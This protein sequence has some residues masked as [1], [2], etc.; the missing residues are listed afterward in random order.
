MVS[1]RKGRSVKIKI[2]AV[3][4]TAGLLVASCGDA[5]NRIARK[6]LEFGGN[7]KITFVEYETKRVWFVKGGKITSEPDK[8]YYFFWAD[9]DGKQKY[10]QVPI[11]GTIIEEI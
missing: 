4:I 3:I 2:A 9:V 10:V 6:G 5:G 7:Y 8:G 11:G 1:N